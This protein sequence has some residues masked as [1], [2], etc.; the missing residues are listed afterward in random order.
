MRTYKIF[1]LGLAAAVALTAQAR[2]ATV[3]ATLDPAQISLGDS[4]QLTVTVKGGEQPKIPDI[5]GLEI[6]AGAEESS[7]SFS[8]NGGSTTS[9]TETK[10]T[11]T[12]TPQ[13]VGTFTIPAIKAGDAKSDPITLRVTGGGNGAQ[14]PVPAPAQTQPQP[15]PG[16]GPV[17]MPPNAPA[18]SIP[19]AASPGG[20]YGT[21]EITLPKKEFYEGE[22]VPAEIKVLL[23][24][25][26]RSEI[27]DLPQFASDGFTLNTLS[28][29]PDKSEED[30]NGRGYT[31]FTWHTAVTAVKAGDFTLQ[32]TVPLTVVVPQR[33]PQMDDEDAINNIFRNPFASMFGVKKK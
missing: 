29:K 5:P 8:M 10:I 32:C 27:T 16:G 6:Q 25:D 1:W 20:K 11:Y 9:S 21:I 7:F 19:A 23:P 3:T 17:V 33:M 13:R 22:L 2:A 28:T 4:A 14:A 18:G 15:T 26:I 12:V 24:G 31:A 30:I